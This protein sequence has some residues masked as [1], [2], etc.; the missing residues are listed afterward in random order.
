M[1]ERWK[2]CRVILTLPLL[3]AGCF[4]ETTELR[5]AHFTAA[6]EAG[7]LRLDVNTTV[8]TRDGEVEYLF[9]DTVGPEETG[10]YLL[11]QR[12]WVT[13][14]D[15]IPLRDVT[16]VSYDADLDLRDAAG[17]THTLSAGNWRIAYENGR[18]AAIVAGTRTRLPLASIHSVTVYGDIIGISYVLGTVLGLTAVVFF[19]LAS[20]GFRM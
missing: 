20:G 17:R 12:S 14:P 16:A 3:L 5:P 18:P 13:K 6:R 19:L 7:V 8:H 1:K 10:T 9:G 2:Y 11:G 15:S 4:H